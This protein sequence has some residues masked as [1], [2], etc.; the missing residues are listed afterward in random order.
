MHLCQ[1]G[2]HLDQRQRVAP[3]L[4]HQ[5][6]ADRRGGGDAGLTGEQFGR[7][8]DI[9]PTQLERRHISGFEPADL[10]L[11]RCEQDHDPLRL[12][13]A[14]D[15]PQRVRGSQVQPM[16]VINQAQHRLALG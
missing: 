2:P 16:S 4:L 11:A 5:P 7:S 3:R 13:T 1:P 12:E 15:K 8:R 10:T 9:E 14:G 6:I